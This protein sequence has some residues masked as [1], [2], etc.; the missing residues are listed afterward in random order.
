MVGINNIEWKGTINNPSWK[1]T[2]SLLEQARMKGD[3]ISFHNNTDG[4]NV[5]RELSLEIDAEEQLFMPILVM[6]PGELMRY[7]N[8][9]NGNPSEEVAFSGGDMSTD[10]LISDFDLIIQM[11]KEFYETGGVRALTVLEGRPGYED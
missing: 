9:P 1:E 10:V 7:Y 3:I 2:L 6:A 11:V 8:N 5:P 4:R